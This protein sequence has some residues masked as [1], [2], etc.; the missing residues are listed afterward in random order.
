MRALMPLSLECCV[1]KDG[2]NRAGLYY[3][4]QRELF[5]GI[6]TAAVAP[7]EG[8]MGRGTDHNTGIY[9]FMFFFMTHQV[10]A[11]G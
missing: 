8:D 4:V 5:M 3:D 2:H 11:D 6:L 7:E 9:Y 10:Q 1:A